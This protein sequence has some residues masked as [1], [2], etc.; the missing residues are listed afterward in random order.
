MQHHQLLNTLYI[1]NQTGYLRLRNDNVRLDV[2]GDTK[3]DVPLH[4]LG[5]IFVTGGTLVSPPLVQ[6]CTEDGISI[7][8]LS[9]SGS[10]AGAVRPPT[11]GNVLLRLAQF[12]TYEDTERS[13][14]IA[15]TIVRGKLKNC[16]N[17]LL[18]RARDAEGSAADQLREARASID[19]LDRRLDAVRDHDE[20][21]GYEGQGTKHYFSVFSQM[22]SASDAFTFDGRNRRP[23]R[24]RVNA[25]L[26][27]VYT[28][29]L[30]DCRAAAEGVGLDPQIGFL[31]EVRPGRPSLALDLMEELRSPLAD[32]LVTTLINRRQVKPEDFRVRPGGA[33]LLTDDARKQVVVAYQKRKQRQVPHA[34]FSD[35]IPFGLVP[36]VQARILARYLRGDIDHYAPFEYR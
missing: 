17:T 16:R 34:L 29:V 19:A 4:H 12:R 8:F 36:H 26:S 2:D 1:L 25:M 7:V 21:R 18:R 6:R 31:H 14:D 20:A 27:F 22:L 15:R 3:I 10:F 35:R 5:A 23:P 11:S 9:R 24:D 33:W 32:R 13:L 30:S 28:L